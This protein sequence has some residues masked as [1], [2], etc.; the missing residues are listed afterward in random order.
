MAA[1]N[2]TKK[3]PPKKPCKEC[4]GTGEWQNGKNGPMM[5]C[6][7]CRG[8]GEQQHFEMI[9]IACG[10]FPYVTGSRG[11]MQDNGTAYVPSYAT[12]LRPVKVLNLKKGAALISK[13][14]ALEQRRDAT[15]EAVH[16]AF[17]AKLMLIAPWAIKK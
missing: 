2:S 8:T 17:K 4:K 14:E 13:L 7:D 15:V 10:Q 5:I 1:N 6:H 12:S 16:D 11:F 9:F 3:K